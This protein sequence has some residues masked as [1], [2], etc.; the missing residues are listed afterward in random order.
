MSRFLNKMSNKNITPEI[1]IILYGKET[2]EFILFRFKTIKYL[3]RLR[4]S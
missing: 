2:A 4:E 1:I 3:D